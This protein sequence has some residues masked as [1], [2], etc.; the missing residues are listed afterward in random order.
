M[1]RK[2]FRRKRSRPSRISRN[3]SGETEENHERAQSE[4]PVSRLRFESIISQ[5]R[6]QN[7]TAMSTHV[8]DA[9]D[10]IVK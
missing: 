1:N 5:I 9:T 8:V 7:V 6:V 3:V 10:S 2:G 4:E